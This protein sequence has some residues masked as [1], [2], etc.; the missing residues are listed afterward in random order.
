MCNVPVLSLQS[1]LSC[2]LTCRFELFSLFVQAADKSP[3]DQQER[4]Q[5]RT[6]EQTDNGSPS[7]SQQQSINSMTTEEWESKYAADGCVDLWVEEE[8]NSGSRLMVSHL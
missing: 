6:A 8:F 4:Q 3:G 7:T 5:Y 1:S 2:R